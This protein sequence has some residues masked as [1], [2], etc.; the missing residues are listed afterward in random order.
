MKKIQVIEIIGNN[1]NEWILSLTDNN[2]EDKDCFEVSSKEE[3][4][5]IKEMLEN[6]YLSK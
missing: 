1:S 2:P 4:F 3:A 6:W 5:R